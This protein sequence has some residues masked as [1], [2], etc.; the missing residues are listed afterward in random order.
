MDYRG[1]LLLVSHDREFLDNV[2]TSTLAFD[3]DGKVRNYAG[4][5]S[6]WLKQRPQNA[7]P[8]S[9]KIKK[10]KAKP[11]SPSTK[12]RKRT[13]KENRELE[14]LPATIEKL[15]LEQSQL[16]ETIADPAFYQGDHEKV[17]RT[18]A[19]LQEALKRSWKL[20]ITVGTN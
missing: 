5:Y 9:A 11:S 14:S 3:E 19:R 2:V 13:F 15:E 18:T 20:A 6:D 8:G 4:G 16:H 10:E 12:T 7:K 17:T 1:T